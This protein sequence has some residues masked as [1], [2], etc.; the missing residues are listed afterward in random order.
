MRNTQPPPA[1]LRCQV[2]TVKEEEPT[3]SF[4]NFFD[5]P[6]VRIQHGLV[7]TAIMRGGRMR[8]QS[9]E[10]SELWNWG[11][12]GFRDVELKWCGFQSCGVNM[13]R[14]SELC[15]VGAY[16]ITGPQAAL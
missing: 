2:R 15:W 9:F 16:V 3:D 4:F 11:V 6:E 7:D 8:F 14:G 13:M 5:P 10:D 12:A 1:S